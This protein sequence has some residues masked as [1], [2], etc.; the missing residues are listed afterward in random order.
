MLNEIIHH[1]EKQ[2][3]EMEMEM[4]TEMEFLDGSVKSLDWTTGLTQTTSFQCREEAYYLLLSLVRCLPSSQYR[5]KV[6]CIFKELKQMSFKVV[7]DHIILF[8]YA[9]TK[10]GSFRSR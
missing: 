6:A 9:S 3:V 8:L 4:E 2:E 5:L 1:M 7:I 10:A